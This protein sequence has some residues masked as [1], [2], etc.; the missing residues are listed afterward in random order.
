MQTAIIVLLVAV[1]ILEIARLSM[2]RPSDELIKETYTTTL[3]TATKYGGV[4][5][6]TALNS[7]IQITYSGDDD[8]GES[9]GQHDESTQV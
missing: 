6:L 2:K 3:V 4:V 5:T 8:G 1:L 9:V 7:G